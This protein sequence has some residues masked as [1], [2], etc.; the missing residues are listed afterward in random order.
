M[1]EWPVDYEKITNHG[2]MIFIKGPSNEV[3][4]FRM[5]GLRIK[6]I[7]GHHSTTKVKV[8]GEGGYAD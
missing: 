7:Q 8:R 3:L 4:E 2:K 1:P 5:E 6:L